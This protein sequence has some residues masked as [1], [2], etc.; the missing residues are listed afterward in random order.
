MSDIEVGR[1][2]VQ[3]KGAIDFGQRQDGAVDDLAE[4]ALLVLG[5][6]SVLR[7]VRPLRLG[8]IVWCKLDEAAIGLDCAVAVAWVTKR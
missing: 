1:G 6:E 4:V 8:R 2:H 3:A 5:D 7:R